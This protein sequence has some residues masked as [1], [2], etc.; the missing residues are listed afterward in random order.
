MGSTRRPQGACVGDLC[1]VD[2]ASGRLIPEEVSSEQLFKK[3]ITEE[4]KLE[5]AEIPCENAESESKGLSFF[6][7]TTSSGR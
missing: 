4:V 5:S 3:R 7:S 2:T 6:R 1:C